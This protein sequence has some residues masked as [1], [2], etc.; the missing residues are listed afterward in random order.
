MESNLPP[1][2]RRKKIAILGGGLG[3]MAAA[4]ELT[5]KDHWYDEY[6]IAIY[7]KGWRLG[8]KGASG[9]GENGRIEE[10]GLHC[11]W[12]FYDNAFGMLRTCYEEMNRTTGPIKTLDEAFKKLDSVY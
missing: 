8:G 11:F 4:F 5:S 9:R 1:R 6:E 3:A 7:Q 10:H 2:L 12:G